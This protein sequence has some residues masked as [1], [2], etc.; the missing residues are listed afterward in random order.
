MDTSAM[1]AK[2]VERMREAVQR[3]IRAFDTWLTTQRVQSDPRRSGR[4]PTVVT[5]EVSPAEEVVR[6]AEDVRR[7]AAEAADAVALVGEYMTPQHDP[8]FNAVREWES[9]HQRGT[10]IEPMDVEAVLHGTDERLKLVDARVRSGRMLFPVEDPSVLHPL[11][12][13]SRVAARWLLSEYQRVPEEAAGELHYQW[14]RRFGF[15]KYPDG[16]GF[17]GSLLSDAPSHAGQPRLRV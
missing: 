10:L 9:M 6:L 15:P 2:D 13:N 8:G 14:A 7:W 1:G 12:W 5:N 17:W 4:R 16:E 11:V 3:F